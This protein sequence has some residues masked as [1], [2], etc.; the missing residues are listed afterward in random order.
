MAAGESI[1]AED[2]Q[3]AAKAQGVTFKEGDIILIH[4]GWT[5]AKLASDP[6]AWVSGEPGLDNAAAVYLA[7][8]NPVGSART[9]GVSKWCRRSRATRSST[10]MSP[11]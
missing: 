1:S 7:G 10:G 9:P 5:D 11:C 4:T 3:A 6:T 2:L 8:L